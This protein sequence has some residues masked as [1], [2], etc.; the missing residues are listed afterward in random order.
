[1]LF[2]GMGELNSLVPAIVLLS[3]MTAGTADGL[4][5]YLMRIG[6]ISLFSFPLIEL[7]NF[8]DQ[9]HP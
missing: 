7:F 8:L 2:Y 3:E 6:F 4:F 1:M 5:L 9:R